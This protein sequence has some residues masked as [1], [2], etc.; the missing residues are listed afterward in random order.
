[1][2]LID[3]SPL[4]S[5][6]HSV[7]RPRLPVTRLLPERELP[8]Y[9]KQLE[10]VAVSRVKDLQPPTHLLIVFH[11]HA[12]KILRSVTRPIGTSLSDSSSSQSATTSA[13]TGK[14]QQRSHPSVE[15][16]TFFKSHLRSTTRQFKLWDAALCCFVMWLVLMWWHSVPLFL[17]NTNK[18][19]LLV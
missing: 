3:T 6:L 4:C 11:T 5:R 8:K 7:L 1:M 19:C 10:K 15:S 18:P 12:V 9:F 13:L 16:C 14:R 17:R 2:R